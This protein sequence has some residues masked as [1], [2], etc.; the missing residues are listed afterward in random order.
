[1]DGCGPVLPPQLL[2]LPGE[3][4]YS[5]HLQD[6]IRAHRQVYKWLAKI[7]SIG[8]EVNIKCST[9]VVQMLW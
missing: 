8:H 3:Q 7:G 6:R 2:V 4:E 5:K 1:M 9:I